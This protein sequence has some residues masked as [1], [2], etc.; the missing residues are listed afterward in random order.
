M[1]GVLRHVNDV[2]HSC[3]I[4]GFP[5]NLAEQGKLLLQDSFM[6]WETNKTLSLLPLKAGKQ[7]QVF[8]YEK[9]IIFSKKIDVQETSK[10]SV[11]YQYKKDVK[12][13]FALWIQNNVICNLLVQIN[14]PMIL[15]SSHSAYIL[16]MFISEISSFVLLIIITLVSTYIY[17][18]S[19]PLLY[20]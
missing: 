19:R 11:G 1:E 5:G 14:P 13:I 20:S 4:R 15:S 10:D 17:R 2:M 16:A 8:L 7:R 6:V 18:Y 9:M 12:V 3:G